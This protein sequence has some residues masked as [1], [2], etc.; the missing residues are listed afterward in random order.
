MDILGLT[1]TEAYL[2]MIG[3]DAASNEMPDQLFADLEIEG[4]LRLEFG[5]WLPVTIEAVLAGADGSGS[6]AD[7]AYTACRQAARAW[8]AMEVLQ[9][10]DISIAQ[11][12]SDGQNEFARQSYKT[13]ELLQRLNATYSRY[14]DMALI[15]L[16]RATTPSTTWLVGSA[17]PSYDP[18]TN[19]TV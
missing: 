8:C 1:T 4:A 2:A 13:A 9:A 7:L 19:T 12:H 5:S 18:V 11:R 3:L 6:A 10:A 17:S 15:N 14:K 16:G